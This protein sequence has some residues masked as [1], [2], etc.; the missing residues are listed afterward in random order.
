[1]SGNTILSPV[2]SIVFVLIAGLTL[3]AWARQR[4][5]MRRDIA[6]VCASLAGLIV[7]QNVWGLADIQ[8]PELALLGSLVLLAQP[9]LLLRVAAYYR[10]LPAPVLRGVLLGLS[11]AGAALILVP[12][13]RPP[14]M[15][16]LLAAYFIGSEGFAALILVQ[17]ALATAGITRTRL[18]LAAAGT[19]F[20]AAASVVAG[21]AAAVPEAVLPLAAV[22]IQALALLSGLSYYLGFAPPR[23]LRRTWQL[24]ALYRF[25]HQTSAQHGRAEILS[26]LSQAA[27]D[28]VGGLA[29]VTALW[30]TE[31]QRLRL[32]LP[33]EWPPEGERRP[34]AAHRPHDQPAARL[35][36]LI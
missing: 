28:A 8:Q 15:W 18:S 12:S 4:D 16:L 23:W 32:F 20:L 11:L 27:T 14:W 1:M 30:E 13:P 21:V 5:G 2:T 33:G 17:G 6:L 36:L 10:A 31:A 22:P 34:F 9:C 35:G 3:L 26:R 19:G 25:L 7:I 29:G 24:P